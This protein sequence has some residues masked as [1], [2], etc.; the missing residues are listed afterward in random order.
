MSGLFA[1]HPDKVIRNLLQLYNL[2]YVPKF[3]YN[4]KQKKKEVREKSKGLIAV[5]WCQTL[6]LRTSP[7]GE[8]EKE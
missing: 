7:K 4:F 5:K 2:L 6:G 3:I 1:W 8:E